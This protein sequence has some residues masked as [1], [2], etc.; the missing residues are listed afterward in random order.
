MRQMASSATATTSA[1]TYNFK[2]NP[3][4]QNSAQHTKGDNKRHPS[5]NSDKSN[6]VKSTNSNM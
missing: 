5:M 6:S 1:N 2:V 3:H 4:H